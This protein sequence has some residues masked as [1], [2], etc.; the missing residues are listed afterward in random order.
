MDHP[1]G[2]DLASRLAEK[3]T[4]NQIVPYE[5]FIVDAAKACEDQRLC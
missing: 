4:I 5:F 2:I 3:S 1:V